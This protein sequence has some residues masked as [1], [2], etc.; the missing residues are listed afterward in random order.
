MK[1]SKLMAVQHKK[2]HG[3]PRLL[4]DWKRTLLH[5]LC[6]ALLAAA[7]FYGM[8]RYFEYRDSQLDKRLEQ[9]Q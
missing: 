8:H 9:L 7:L 4:S 6:W 3:K 1:N 2:F 5:W